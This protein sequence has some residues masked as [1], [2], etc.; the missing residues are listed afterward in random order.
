MD[1]RIHK[2]NVGGFAICTVQAS[3]RCTNADDHIIGCGVDSE[4]KLGKPK[5][6]SIKEKEVK[7]KKI[8]SKFY[9]EATSEKVVVLTYV[10]VPQI[11]CSIVC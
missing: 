5:T 11:T 2:P 7:V 1:R 10:Y 9:G 6:S 3:Q 8:H 4:S